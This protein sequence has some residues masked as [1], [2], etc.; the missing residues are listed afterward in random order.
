MG[1][2]SFSEA[3]QSSW[4]VLLVGGGE[5][6]DFWSGGP[7]NPKRKKAMSSGRGLEASHAFADFASLL[8]QLWGWRLPGVRWRKFC[9]FTR[10]SAVE[11]IHEA[12]AYAA[13]RVEEFEVPLAV[14]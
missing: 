3:I 2:R 11:N 4:W 13:W 6:I 1:R 5:V 8:A 10:I 9:I 7:H 14:A 12:L